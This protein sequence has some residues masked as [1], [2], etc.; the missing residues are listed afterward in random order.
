MDKQT[1]LDELDSLYEND[2]I[3]KLAYESLKAITDASVEVK[4]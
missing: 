4:E 3:D 1:I 2:N